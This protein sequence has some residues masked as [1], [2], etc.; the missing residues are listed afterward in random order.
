MILPLAG[1]HSLEIF[2]Q[3]TD[4]I[5]EID[6][7]YLQRMDKMQSIFTTLYS[8]EAGALILQGLASS[9]S[10]KDMGKEAA[11]E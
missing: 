5:P 1:L 9:S 10:L 2:D 6:A 4:E 3:A 7:F 8:K 11:R